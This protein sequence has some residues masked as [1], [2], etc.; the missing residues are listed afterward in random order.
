M[1]ATLSSSSFS[2][3]LRGF[4]SFAVSTNLCT[5]VC[6][7]AP[8]AD[9]TKRTRLGICSPQIC[10]STRYN[11][12]WSRV[13]F[14]ALALLVPLLVP[15]ASAKPWDSAT[16]TS[17]TNLVLRVQPVAELMEPGW[18]HQAG[19]AAARWARLRRHRLRSAVACPGAS[20]VFIRWRFSRC[21]IL[22]LRRQNNS[23][24]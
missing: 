7:A 1:N 24:W 23:R 14:Q 3:K 19:S 11:S 10:G 15:P 8:E 13:I 16:S 12:I 17:D 2:S 6:S 18:L 22:R 4:E 5:N 20:S 9:F 21:E